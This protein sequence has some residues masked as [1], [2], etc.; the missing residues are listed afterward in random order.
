MEPAITVGLYWL[1]F[2]GTHLVLATGR[3]R[4]WLVA[5][6]GDRGFELV[7][8]LVATATLWLLVH[9]FAGLRL[10]G[11]DGPGLAGVPVAR[12]ALY[13]VACGGMTLAL[14]GVLVYPASPMAPP[15]IVRPPRGL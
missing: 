3:P 13:A 11:A 8:T 1:L 15:G 14:A 2:G 5:R 10:A 12:A 4:A 7:F 9:A 6:V